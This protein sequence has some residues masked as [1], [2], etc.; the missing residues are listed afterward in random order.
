MKVSMFK[1]AVVASVAI[2]TGTIGAQEFGDGKSATEASASVVEVTASTIQQGEAAGSD[3]FEQ[4]L[5]GAIAVDQMVAEEPVPEVPKS[6]T[7]QISM[8]VEDKEYQIGT[9]DEA[10]DRIVVQESIKFDIPNP[11]VSS[12]YLNLR[13]EKMSELLLNAKAEIIRTMYS[14]VSAERILEIPGNPI[15]KQVAEERGNIEKRIEESRRQ[16]E[17]LGVNLDEAA[18]NKKSMTMSELMASISAWF[19]KSDKENVAAKYDADKKELY[20]HAKMDFERAKEEYEGMLEKAE[21]AKGRITKQLTS[22]MVLVSSLQIHGCTVLQQADSVSNKNGKYQY[23]ICILYS[24]SGERMAASQC[25]LAAKP[26]KLKPGKNTVQKWLAKKRTSGALADWIGPRSYID[27]NGDLWFMGIALAPCDDNADQEEQN[28]KIA[29]LEARAEVGYSI[30]ADATTYQDVNKLMQGK[31]R[32]NLGVADQYGIYKAYYER[33]ME[34]FNNL[35]LYGLG[36]LGEYRVKDATGQDVY[37]V[38]YGINASTAKSMRNIRDKMHVV[39]LEVNS[40]QEFERGRNQRMDQQTKASRNNAA[41]RSAGAR[42]ADTMS[43]DA[44]AKKRAVSA[45]KAGSGMKGTSAPAE[46]TQTKGRLQTGTRFVADED[47]E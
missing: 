43:R 40:L 4:K 23:E 20:A 26:L 9:Y 3:G 38:I 16:L 2:G 31:D 47:D 33:S 34:R 44:A 12:D 30:Y 7:E 39:G 46:P 25:V 17:K 10:K 36:K 37:T 1:F 15:A 19:V 14:S 24:W 13:T 27:K 22:T 28:L 8:Y 42:D 35:N 29:R 41:A 32:K 6:A 11:E 45:R 21:T 18:T 5:D